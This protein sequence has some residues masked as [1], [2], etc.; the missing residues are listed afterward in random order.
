[1]EVILVHLDKNPKFWTGFGPA[2]RFLGVYLVETIDK[3][4]VFGLGSMCN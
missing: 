4:L 2:G 1:M 3:G